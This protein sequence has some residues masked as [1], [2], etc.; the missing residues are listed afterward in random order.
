MGL[1]RPADEILAKLKE[2]LGIPTGH[3][4]NKVLA[5]KLGVSPQTISGWL[6]QGGVVW[7]AIAEAVTP[8]KFKELYRWAHAPDNAAA[9]GIPLVSYAGAGTL[10]IDTPLEYEDQ[11]ELVLP[12]VKVPQNSVAL[13]IRGES[14]LPVYRDGDIVLV[15]PCE[16]PRHGRDYVFVGP[17][18]ETWIKTWHK[19]GGRTE[20]RSHN[21]SVPPI[22]LE[23]PARA[24]SIL[25]HIRKV[26]QGLH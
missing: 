5:E 3:G 26:E 21:P 25:W 9:R 19:A 1:I 18:G 2:M 7:A 4:S 6:A 24:F 16:H 8:N 17:G 12:P 11:G 23:K 14:M 15:S 20:L 10:E 22:V 13:R